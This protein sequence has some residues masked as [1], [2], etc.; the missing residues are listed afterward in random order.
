MLAVA[1]GMGSG[2][3]TAVVVHFD[4]GGLCRGMVIGSALSGFV[5]WLSGSAPPHV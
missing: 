1:L 5:M 2:G 3:L 4:I